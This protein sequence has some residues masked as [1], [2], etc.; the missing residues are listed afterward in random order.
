MLQP[1]LAQSPNAALPVPEPKLISTPYWWEG[2]RALPELSTEPPADNELVIIGGGFTGLSAALTA[3]GKGVAVTVIDA[4]KPGQ[5]A[6]TRNGG[7]IGAPH[8]PGFVKELATYGKTVASEL[9]REGAAAYE[10]TRSLYTSPDMDSGFQQT[11]RIQ[12]ANTRA[13]FTAMKKRVALLNEI[14]DQGIQIVERGALG[15]HTN[16][17][18]YFGALLYPDHGGIHPRRAH[19]ALLARAIACWCDDLCGLPGDRYCCQCQRI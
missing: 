16:S 9:V 15:A 14:Q 6:S 11:G 10:F 4:A 7:M 18:I 17:S 1:V 12:L 8:R 5:G 3:A 19:D 13:A 2:G